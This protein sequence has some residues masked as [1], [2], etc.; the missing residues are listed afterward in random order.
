M[1]SAAMS[2]MRAYGRVLAHGQAVARVQ[3]AV[4]AKAHVEKQVARLDVD[5]GGPFVDRLGDEDV[6]Q[7]DDRGVLGQFAQRGRIQHPAD[8]APAQDPQQ[9]LDILL[10]RQQPGWPR[11]RKALGKRIGQ[12]KVERIGA[13]RMQR[14]LCIAPQQHPV[15]AHPGRHPV[16]RF[17]ADLE[18]LEREILGIELGESELGRQHRQQGLFGERSHAHQDGAEAAAVRLLKGQRLGDVGL[19]GLAL[20][21]QHLADEGR[22]GRAALARERK[23]PGSWTAFQGYAGSSAVRAAV[24]QTPM[25]AARKSAAREDPAGDSGRVPAARHQ[26]RHG[27]YRKGLPGAGVPARTQPPPAMPLAA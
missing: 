26:P 17:V 1:S 10:A 27:F 14:T 16:V 20:R 13:S 3:H 19:A 23:W 18:L 22:G 25:I 11:T 8:L 6:D 2:L 15:F 12:V 24:L 21:D 4:D 9:A 5:V 7:R